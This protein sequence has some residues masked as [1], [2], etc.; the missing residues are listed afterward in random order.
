MNIQYFS[1]NGYNKFYSPYK[2]VWRI[3]KLILKACKASF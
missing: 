1:D 2:A 3:P